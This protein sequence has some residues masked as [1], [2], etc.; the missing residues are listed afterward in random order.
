MTIKWP[1]T[2]LAAGLLL[3]GIGVAAYGPAL[4]PTTSSALNYSVQRIP[5]TPS[6]PAFDLFVPKFFG[7]PHYEFSRDDFSI[8]FNLGQGQ[9]D[10]LR[11]VVST[12]RLAQGKSLGEFVDEQEVSPKNQTR[13]SRSLVASKYPTLVT[14][15]SMNSGLAFYDVLYAPDKVLRLLFSRPN[16]RHLDDGAIASF[17]TIEDEIVGTMTVFPPPAAYSSTESPF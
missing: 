4:H 17:R 14:I 13:I 12:A 6:S 3:C 11:I 15:P 10:Y 8:Q 16:L 2:L 9:D 7:Q 1:I 5:S